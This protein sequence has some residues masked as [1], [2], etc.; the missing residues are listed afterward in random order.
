[1]MN[2]WHRWIGAVGLLAGACQATH[3]AAPSPSRPVV[4]SSV[5][6]RAPSSSP[7][8]SAFQATPAHSPRVSAN[9]GPPSTPPASEFPIV[10]PAPNASPPHPAVGSI[11]CGKTSCRTGQE[12]CCRSESSDSATS[13]CVRAAPQQLVDFGALDAFCDG[14]GKLLVA[15]DESESCGQGQACCEIMWGSGQ[16]EP[17]VCA[18]QRPGERFPCVYR[19]ACVRGSPCR[20]TGAKCVDG[21]CFVEQ[22][23]RPLRC[24]NSTCSAPNSTCCAGWNG[25]L[26]CTMR[27]QCAGRETNCTSPSDCPRGEFCGV[28]G[29]GGR[30]MHSWDGMTDILCETVSDC[31]EMREV[32]A[33]RVD[34]PHENIACSRTK[35]KDPTHPTT[36]PILRGRRTCTCI[37]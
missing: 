33:S 36:N 15:C 25:Q 31:H 29:G 37:E 34:P 8:P 10:E 3:I 11:M 6:A 22:P 26:S 12:A 7:T 14:L 32:C 23:K 18:P 20:T 19:E 9:G 2:T 17:V 1:M 30:C 28:M 16:N 13:V 4:T 35:E 21:W 27:D 24:G 5:A